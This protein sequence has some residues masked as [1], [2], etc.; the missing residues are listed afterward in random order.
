L[1]RQLDDTAFFAKVRDVVD[2][3]LTQAGFQTTLGTLQQA[4][5][6]AITGHLVKVA[7]V[8]AKKFGLS[9]DEQGGVLNALIRGGDLTA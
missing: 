8:T 7:E 5:R 6:Q 3:S 9:E 1:K 4:S 2:A